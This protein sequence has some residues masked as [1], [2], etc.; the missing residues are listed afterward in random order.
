MT[1]APLFFKDYILKN[2]TTDRAE[3]C[4]AVTLTPKPTIHTFKGGGA[5]PANF[6]DLELDW[7]LDLVFGQDFVEPTSL[8]RTLLAGAGTVGEGWI[9]EPANGAGP[10]FT[11]DVL[12]V[13]GA[14][15]GTGRAHATASVS[16]EVI[17]QPVF[18]DGV[19]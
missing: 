14:A 13:P 1:Y 3:Q 19:A 9:F 12:M 2:P 8:S 4:S 6:K 5:V 15:G 11:V 17:G 16:L 18:D 7:T 10:T